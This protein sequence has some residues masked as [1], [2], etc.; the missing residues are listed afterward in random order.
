MPLR[1][2]STRIRELTPKYR[3]TTKLGHAGLVEV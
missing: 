3:E 1:Y 2:T